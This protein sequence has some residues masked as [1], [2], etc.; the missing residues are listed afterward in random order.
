MNSEVS[1]LYEEFH[2]LTKR[3][4]K[5]IEIDDFTQGKLLKI[6]SKYLQGRKKILDIGCGTGSKDFFLAKEGHHVDGI[7]I[8][9]RAIK[10]CKESSKR[11]GLKNASFHVSSI[12][13]YSKKKQYDIILMIEVI[14]HIKNDKKILNLVSKLLSKNGILVLS[15]PSINS[16]LYK[17]GFLFEFDKKV[18]HIRRYSLDEIVKLT[19]L[20]DLRIIYTEKTEGILRNFI[21]TNKIGGLFLKI[22]N[23]V[24]VIALTV[25]L[26]DN[27]L[28][29][30]FGESD[31]I[32]VAQK[33]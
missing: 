31:L 19:T 25:T 29:R 8:S 21:F 30:I 16:P 6:L 15:T 3:H 24:K 4:S 28:L 13:K 5:I 26:F 1:D 7:D 22:I 11:F 33:K 17:W 12:E 14:E 32:I 18:G 27:I 20:N 9:E 10:S 23:R 2:K